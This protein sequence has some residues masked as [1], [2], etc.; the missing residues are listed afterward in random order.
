MLVDQVKVNVRRVDKARRTVGWSRNRGL[1]LPHHTRQ[2]R[3]E[4]KETL[5]GA[6]WEGCRQALIAAFALRARD[7]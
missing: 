2:S 4:T 3:D 7:Q 1:T 6:R 5:H